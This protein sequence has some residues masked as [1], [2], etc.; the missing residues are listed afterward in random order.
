[1][2]DRM[3]FR[4]GCFNLFNLVEMG[5]PFYGNMVYEEQTYEKKIRWVSRQLDDMRAD[6]VGFQE[7]FHLTSLREALARSES[8]REH[9]LAID[10][11]SGSHP[12]VALA[13]RYPI[14][15]YKRIE[16]FPRHGRLELDEG[17]HVPRE[18]FTHAILHARVAITERLKTHV[19]VVHLKS[20]RPKFLNDEDRRDPLNFARAKARSLIIRAAEACAVRALLLDVMQNSDDPVIVIGDL[21]DADV[22]VTTEVVAGDPPPRR[23][24]YRDKKRAW[25]VLLYNTKAIQ[26]RQS[27]RDVYYTHIHN[28]QY[29]SLDHILVSEQFYRQNRSAPAF[30]EYVTVFNDHLIDET[31]S[32]DTYP[33]WTSDHG[34]VVATICV[35]DKHS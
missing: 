3:R 26:A 9:H 1:M 6:L 20:K 33:M 27:H 17:L 4:V 28:G 2:D 10:G 19:F 15:E 22:A 30:V 16:K 35:R 7:V 18:N 21:N 8:L 32:N 5:I 14:L 25:D 29:E 12:E 11:L 34:Q 23:W 24:D 13:S 31:I